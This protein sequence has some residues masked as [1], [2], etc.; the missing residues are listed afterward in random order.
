[1]EKGWEKVFETS[2]TITAEIVKTMLIEN[3]IPAVLINGN[4]SSYGIFL[5]GRAEI[6]VPLEHAAD[7]I[8][9]IETNDETHE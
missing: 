4:D 8:N 1:M 5:P 3:E 6:Y 9:L 7:A 2:N